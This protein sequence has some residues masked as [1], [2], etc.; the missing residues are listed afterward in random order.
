MS[1][2]RIADGA[3][4]KRVPAGA[5]GVDPLVVSTAHTHLCHP[6]PIQNDNGG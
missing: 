6:A 3:R 5:A 2:R 4:P 1:G